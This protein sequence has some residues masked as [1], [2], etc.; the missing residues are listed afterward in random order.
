MTIPSDHPAL[1]GHFPGNPIVPGVVILDTVIRLAQ[2][3]KYSIAAVTRAKFKAPL[4]PETPFHVE[5]SPSGD[6][7]DFRVLCAEQLLVDGTLGC[8]DHN[9]PETT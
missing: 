3:W 7:L 4:L 5:L 2:Q 6:G 8:L 9:P 1:S